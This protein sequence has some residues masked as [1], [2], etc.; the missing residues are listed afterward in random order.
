MLL[1]LATPFVGVAAPPA[2]PPGF[3]FVDVS[4]AAG[5]DI[6]QVAAGPHADYIIESL[7]AGAAW[8]DY[9]GDGDADLYLAQGAEPA[10]PQA[11]PPDRLLRND[12]DPDG[13]RVPNFKD[14]TRESGLGDT[15]WSVGVAVADYD[16]DGDP[17]IYLTNW[18]PNRL[19]RNK[20]DGTFEEI[21]ERAGLADSAWSVSAA[22]CDIDRDGDLDLYVTNYVEFAFERYPGR[23]DPRTRDNS[24]CMWRGVPVFC[25]PRGL[26]PAPDRLYRNDGLKD[27]MPSFTDVAAKAG[28]TADAPHYGLAVHCFDPDN[29]GDDDIYVANDAQ[30]NDFFMNRGDGTFR[31]ASLLAGLGFNEDGAE[32]AGM[33]ISSGDYDGD[34]LLDVAV[35]NFS[36]EHD[37]LYRN[38]GQGFFTDVSYAAGLGTSSWLNLGWGIRFVDVDQDGWEDLVVP[39]GHVFP[40]VDEVDVGTTF[41]QRNGLYRNLGNGTFAEIGRLSGPGMALVKSSRVLLPADIDDDGDPDLLVTNWNDTPDLLRNDGAP[42]N[43]LQ[44]RLEGSRSNRDGIGARV[45]LTIPGRKQLREIRREAGF[46]GSTLPVAHFGLGRAEKVQHL[47]V[48]WPSGAVTRLAGVSANQRLVLREEAAEAAEAPAGKPDE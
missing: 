14:V 24:A 33:G 20:G 42:G 35:S 37:T 45:T 6:V 23:G 16:N 13:D 18:G 38:K 15:L 26:E 8:L 36:H 17:D 1:G 7:G 30:Q 11:G 21:G 43:W 41:R 27:G 4:H 44:V 47:E 9:D 10:A 2:G 34:G 48:R 22:W 19:Y 29:D 28:L 12:G 32:Q 25:G 3:R 39:Y 46:A 40:Q 31:S 5:L